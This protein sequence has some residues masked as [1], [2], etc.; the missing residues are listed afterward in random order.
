MWLR[1][2]ARFAVALRF[3]RPFIPSHTPRGR[4]A[5]KKTGKKYELFVKRDEGHGYR[6]EE[7]AVELYQRI[8]AFL[9][10]HVPR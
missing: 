10:A 2:S 1:K 3:S 4:A 7:N 6:K 8:D 5:L 9:K